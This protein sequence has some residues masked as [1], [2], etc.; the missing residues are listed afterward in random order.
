MQCH[1]D[2]MLV[3]TRI[4][5][6]VANDGRVTV[7]SGSADHGIFLK[8]LSDPRR[9][10]RITIRPLAYPN[11]GIGRDAE[12]EMIGCSDLGDE[13]VNRPNFHMR[14]DPPGSLGKDRTGSM[15]MGQNEHAIAIIAGEPS[16]RVPLH[17]FNRTVS[18]D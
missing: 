2:R 14:T 9:Q 6:L 17:R 10:L 3:C 18:L 15:C 7:C 5:V 16:G 13:T 1:R 12:P 4:L 11:H 8:Q